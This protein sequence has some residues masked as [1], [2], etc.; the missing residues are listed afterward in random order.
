[1]FKYDVTN[2]KVDYK[3]LKKTSIEIDPNSLM[4]IFQKDQIVIRICLFL[5][6]RKL[7]FLLSCTVFRF[8]FSNKTNVH[9]RYCPFVVFQLV[10]YLN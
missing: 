2:D 1:M 3:D 6:V 4:I 5:F 7:V 9:C 10:F 8:S